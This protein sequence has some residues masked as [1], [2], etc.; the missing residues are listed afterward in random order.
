VVVYG[1]IACATEIA[2]DDDDSVSDLSF[3]GPIDADK[4]P[5]SPAVPP[6]SELSRHPVSKSNVDMSREKQ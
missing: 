5:D 1:L 6:A 2:D 4:L 3:G